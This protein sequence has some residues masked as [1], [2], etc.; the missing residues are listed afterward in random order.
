APPLA[1][2]MIA[3]G[4]SVECVIMLLALAVISVVSAGSRMKTAA[5]IAL[6]LLLGTIGL[7]HLT[8]LPRF[9]FGSPNLA[10]G[11]SFTALAIG[12]FGIS[13]ILTN[14]EKTE[15]IKAIR[16]KLRDL[17]PRWIDLKESAP[18]VGRGSIIGFIFGIVPGVSH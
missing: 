9:T 18:A 10:G 2:V 13:E 12:L 17:V 7:D 4:P 14:L 6:G 15:S 11:L 3:I 8:G 1:K 5:M 16:P